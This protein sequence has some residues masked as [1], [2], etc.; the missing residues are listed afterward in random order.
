MMCWKTIQSIA[1]VYA[2][3]HR[4]NF[5]KIPAER[6]TVKKFCSDRPEMKPFNEV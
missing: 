4:G 2:A 5:K 6:T 1:S 3:P